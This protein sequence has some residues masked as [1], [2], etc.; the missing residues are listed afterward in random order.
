MLK[1][2]LDIDRQYKQVSEK[3]EALEELKDSLRSRNMARL[4]SQFGKYQKV[5]W[6]EQSARLETDLSESIDLD[7]IEELPDEIRPPLEQSTR[8]VQSV[9]ELRTPLKSQ[10]TLR[11]K[12]SFGPLLSGRKSASKLHPSLP[13]HNSSSKVFKSTV[14]NINY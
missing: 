1:H 6:E 11:P 9:Q 10:G 14:F 13:T 4:Q 7:Y 3:K 12:A 8:H 2:K 5:S